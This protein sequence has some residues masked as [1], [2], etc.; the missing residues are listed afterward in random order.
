MVTELAKHLL[1]DGWQ[2]T[3]IEHAKG[4]GV[5]KVLL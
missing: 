4:R 1:G 3:F 2:E 5:E